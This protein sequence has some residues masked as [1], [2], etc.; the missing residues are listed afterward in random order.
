MGIL[1]PLSGPCQCRG[2]PSNGIT[3]ACALHGAVPRMDA[4]SLL[5]PLLFREALLDH[6][7][8]L[9]SSLPSGG[10]IHP[11]RFW[12]AER[13][14]QIQGRFTTLRLLPCLK[15]EELKINVANG[16][17]TPSVYV[18]NLVFDRNR[19]FGF[20]L[21]LASVDVLLRSESTRKAAAS[22]GA[23]RHPG[24]RHPEGDLDRGLARDA[25]HAG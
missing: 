3:R 16:F 20:L 4:A 21:I 1:L 23:H 9:Q 19:S 10:T 22:R 5:Q 18:H 2:H 15:E 13:G 8:P 7:L 12:E 17:K 24:L 14:G 25:A 6:I 11:L